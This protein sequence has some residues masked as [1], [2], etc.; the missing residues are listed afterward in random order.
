MEKKQKFDLNLTSNDYELNGWYFVK[1]SKWMDKLTI[2]ISYE[3]SVNRE[4]CGY[5]V[6]IR[7][8]LSVANPNAVETRV[9]LMHIH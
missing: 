3:N 5:K 7:H 6:H 1:D 8:F 4:N 2:C 9:D